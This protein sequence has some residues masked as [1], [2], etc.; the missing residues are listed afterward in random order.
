TG[1][2]GFSGDGGPATS[3][4]LGGARG[5]A[6]DADGN[7][8]IADFNN[9]RIRKVTAAGLITTVAGIG[10]A[11]PFSGGF[12]GDGGPA[13]AAQLNLP[14]GV[15]VDG[16]NLLSA[17]SSNQ[18][19][20]K[21]NLAG[22]ITTVAGNGAS[23]GFSGDLGLATAAELNGPWDAV[24]DAEGDL[25]IAA[26]STHRIRKVTADGIITTVAGSNASAFSGDGGLATAARL[27]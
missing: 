19:V 13:A 2:F 6:V 21:I 10:S 26:T 9:N 8:F 17:D 16:G 18:R 11:F 25:F 14:L 22:V 1:T 15:A 4:Q 27:S 20:R 12:S 7:L 3:A 24:G 23:T 5:V